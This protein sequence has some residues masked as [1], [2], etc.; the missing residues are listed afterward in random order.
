MF[1]LY[2]HTKK[3]N[4][5]QD[6]FAMTRQNSQITYKFQLVKLTKTLDSS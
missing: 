5:C 2:E 4:K 3:M 6:F 1:I